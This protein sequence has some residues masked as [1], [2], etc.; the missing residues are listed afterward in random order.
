MILQTDVTATL[1]GKVTRVVDGDTLTVLVDKTP[2]AIHLESIDA[3]E[4]GQAFSKKSKQALN[5]KT[6]GK[7]VTVLVTGKDKYSRT[8]SVVMIDDRIINLEMVTE[9]W[10]WCYDE[11]NKDPQVQELEDEARAKKV[12]MWAAGNNLEPWEFTPNV[13]QRGCSRV[14]GGS[15]SES[16]RRHA[17]VDFCHTATPSVSL[18]NSFNTAG[19]IAIFPLSFVERYSSPPASAMMSA[20]SCCAK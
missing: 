9:G 5:D 2:T 12:G 13:H 1:T 16:N 17:C 15:T 11:H 6:A 20:A 8:I 10:A 14:P 3:P 18:R 19:A 4:K 7:T